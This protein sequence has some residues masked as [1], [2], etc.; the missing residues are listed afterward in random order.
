MVHRHNQWSRVWY[1]NSVGLIKRG[2]GDLR[3]QYGDRGLVIGA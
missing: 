2:A 3:L 1:A